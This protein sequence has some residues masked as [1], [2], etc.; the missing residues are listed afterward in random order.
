MPAIL[1]AMEFVIVF[2]DL[3]NKQT[4]SSNGEAG[5]VLTYLNLL[6]KR[7]KRLHLLVRRST[8]DQLYLALP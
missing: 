5:Y 3:Y 7:M 1:R 2:H 8:I 6:N 4:L